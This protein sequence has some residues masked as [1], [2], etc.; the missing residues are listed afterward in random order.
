MWHDSQIQMLEYLFSHSN[1]LLQFTNC[2][3]VLKEP[4]HPNWSYPVYLYRY[5]A[6]LKTMEQ[7]QKVY[8]P[9]YI[10]VLK[11]YSKCFQ[12]SCKRL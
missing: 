5:Y 7:L 10:I 12:A 9:R 6:A 8:I 4:W 3:L 2:E 1:D 11:E